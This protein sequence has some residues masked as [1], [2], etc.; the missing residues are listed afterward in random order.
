MCHRS[1]STNDDLRALYDADVWEHRQG[2][3]LGTPEYVAL[4]ERD[5]AR[6]QRTTDLI[7]ARRV[8]DE[9]RAYPTT[10]DQLAALRPGPV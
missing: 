4:R 3:R 8:C 5:L 10:V 9:R 7:A 6:R 1:A 2:Y